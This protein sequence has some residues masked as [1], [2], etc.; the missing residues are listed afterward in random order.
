[1][2]N[3]SVGPL[4]LITG[5]FFFTVLP[6]EIIK[7]P[8]NMV[9][10]VGDK[11]N[12]RCVG[13]DGLVW[14]KKHVGVTNPWLNI[15]DKGVVG[16]KSKYTINTKPEDNYELTIKSVLLIDAGGYQCKTVLRFDEYAKAELIVFGKTFFQ[17]YPSPISACVVLYVVQSR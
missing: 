4:T 5:V 12:F 14:A 16:N 7:G 8:L 17:F 9:A 3:K 13:K 10:K 15:V 11:V 2:C 1:M 6:G